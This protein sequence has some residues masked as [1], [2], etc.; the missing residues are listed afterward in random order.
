MIDVVTGGSGSGK[1]EFAEGLAADMGGRLIYLATMQ[2]FGA[3]AEKRIERHKAMRSGKGFETVEAFTA[4]Q[5]AS[6]PD[7]ST[8]L[9]ECVSN[10][11]ANEMFSVGGDYVESVKECIKALSRRSNNLIAVTNE[12]FSDGICYD[13]ET[14]NYIRAMAEINRYLFSVADS[15]TEV[16]YSIPIRLK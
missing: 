16:V 5:C 14:V 10:L 8:V 2:P 4:A 6:V 1:S 3:E 12:I 11:L 15:V 9:L 13:Q 7:R